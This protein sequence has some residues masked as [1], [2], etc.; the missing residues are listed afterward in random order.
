MKR[1]SVT[2]GS[3]IPSATTGQRP[4]PVVDLRVSTRA[5]LWD[6]I[7]HTGLQVVEAM[8]E[9][10]RRTLCGPRYQHDGERVATRAGTVASAVVVGGRKVAIRRP[11]VRA[12]GREVP[13]P[14][15]TAFTQTEPLT[16]RTVEQ[17][18][19]GVATRRYERS[20]DPL[21]PGVRSRSTSKSAVSRRFIAR[22]RAQLE[23]W[24]TR[25]LDEVELAVLF[26]DGVQ[27]A[28]QCVVVAL[29]IDTTGHK[30][31][32]GLWDGS[33]ENTAVCQGLLANLTDRGLRTDR[34]LLVV[35][36]GSKALRKAVD[37]SL[38]QAAWV[39]RCQVHK[40]RNVL[41]YLPPGQQG[42]ARATLQRAYR[43]PE[44]A[45]AKR[46]LETLARRLEEGYPS[47]AASLRE[48]LEETLTVV[49]LHVGDTLRRAL[50]TTNTIE[51]LMGGL[52]Q[53]H[54]NVKRWRGRRMVLRWAVAGVLEAAKGFKRCRGHQDMRALINVL[55]A[56]DER[57]GLTPVKQV[58]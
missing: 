17:M 58:A 2:R 37:Q 49:A 34:S 48:G 7:V 53:V 14:T 6:V 31:V 57:L 23:T 11:R 56:R 20:L 19:I 32:L 25:P 39:Q 3:C 12:G 41:S 42:A 16:R 40:L 52:R 28:R 38:G 50:A 13:L 44:V 5:E 29:G 30:Q 27:F 4:L 18:V 9:E 15:F 35:L 10:D 54:R 46:Q 47:A 22:T 24:Q 45:A 8:L 51:N 55:R 43:S 36:D 26:I 33:T 1:E 21:P